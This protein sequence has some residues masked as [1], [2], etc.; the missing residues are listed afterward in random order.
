MPWVIVEP[1]LTGPRS[2]REQLRTYLCDWPGCPN[3]GEHVL[4]CVAELA[5]FVAVCDEHAKSS[6][7]D[8]A[9]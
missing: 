9:A 2:Y 6:R 3:P 4:G 1:G 7:R 8:A 5:A